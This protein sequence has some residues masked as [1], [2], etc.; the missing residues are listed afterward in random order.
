VIAALRRE[1]RFM[2]GEPALRAWLLVVLLLSSAAVA[3]GLHEV[4]MQR[5]TLVQ[6]L[7]LDRAEREAQVARQTEW[8]SAGYNTFHLTYDPP[9]PFAFAALGER[10]T[11]PWKHRIRMLA[12]EGQIHES[13]V[14][15]PE[16]ALAGRLD[17][18][19]VAAFLLPLLIIVALHDLQARE[20]QAGRH[21]LLRTMAGGELW[22]LRAGLRGVALGACVLVPMWMGGAISGAS[23]VTLLGASGI[24][25]LQAVFWSAMCLACAS[26]GRSAATTLALLVAAWWLL[27]VMVPYGSRAMVERS[28]PMPDG[29]R[30]ALVQREAVHGAWDL[31]KEATMA[32]FTR[33]Y[34]EWAEHAEVTRPFEWKWYYAFQEVGDLEAADLSRRYREGIAR[35]D[36][37]AARWAWLS[38]PALVERALQRLAA[39]DVPAHLRYLDSVRGFHAALREFHYPK[40]FLEQSFDPA[41]ATA[42]PSYTPPRMSP[43]PAR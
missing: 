42:L 41:L 28:V 31:P 19:F 2:L 5:A 34:P 24:V 14:G 16:L 17:I 1:L 26:L 33:A 13:D 8:G 22:M 11:M 39:T 7:E 40:L 10:D 36:R 32:A 12:L 20:R 29:A 18:A 3:A 37:L 38:P 35:R 25:M 9:S 23:A 43:P 6:L 15:N 4:S 21:D 30:I 27:A